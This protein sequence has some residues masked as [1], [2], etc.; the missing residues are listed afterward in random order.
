MLFRSVSVPV[1]WGGLLIA[2][3]DLDLAI[4]R[5]RYDAWLEWRLQELRATR[6]K[7][8]AVLCEM[9]HIEQELL[10]LGCRR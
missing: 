1:N 3:R 6:P 7:T 5:E 10:P 2:Q 8:L 9:E 4:E